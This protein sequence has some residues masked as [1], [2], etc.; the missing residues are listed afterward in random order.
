MKYKILK[1]LEDLFD[2]KHETTF[3]FKKVCGFT[4]VFVKN[5]ITSRESITSAEIRPAGIIYEE[6]DEYY[7]APLHKV[8]NIEPIIREFVKTI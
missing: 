8:D 7:F 3:E 1:S 6:N 2:M 5:I 4:F